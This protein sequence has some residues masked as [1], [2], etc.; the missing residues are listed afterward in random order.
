[1]KIII[2]RGLYFNSRTILNK[3]KR[4]LSIIERYDENG[5]IE[6]II[7]TTKPPI[8]W[9]DKDN[10]KKQVNTWKIDDLKKK[11]MK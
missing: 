2:Q 6:Q 4:L 9:K 3:S 11:F 10:V 1:M 7:A 5:N 8:F